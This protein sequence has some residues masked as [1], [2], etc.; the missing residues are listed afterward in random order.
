[1]NGQCHVA[2]LLRTARE[3][4]VS[5]KRPSPSAIPSEYS[6]SQVLD[7]MFVPSSGDRH[8][9]ESCG[10]ATGIVQQRPRMTKHI[11]RRALWEYHGLG[12]VHTG[13]PVRL[14]QSDNRGSVAALHFGVVDQVAA[15]LVLSAQ[16][17]TDHDQRVKFSRGTIRSRKKCRLPETARGKWSSS[18]GLIGGGQQLVCRHTLKPACAVCEA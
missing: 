12:I 10:N 2:Y 9:S 5:G 16:C 8:S 18:Q 15:T 11:P 6:F 7:F 13:K 3:R 17:L 1:M 4:C 14:A